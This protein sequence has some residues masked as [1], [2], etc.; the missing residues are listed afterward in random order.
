MADPDRRTRRRH[1]ALLAAQL[2]GAWASGSVLMGTVALLVVRTA[3]VALPVQPGPPGFSTLGSLAREVS[4]ARLTPLERLAALLLVALL[5]VALGVL[6]WRTP[7]ASW[8]A[9]DARARVLWPV[10]VGAGGLAGWSFAATVT[11]AAGFGPAAQLVLAY[12]GGG[13]PFALVAAML[14]RPWQVNVAALG[15]SALLVGAGILMMAGQPAAVPG[16]L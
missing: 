9:G 4:L 5:F 12:L 14:L 15:A 10:L 6:G 13:L 7:G 3:S 8:I 11:Y 1:L 16:V 2:A